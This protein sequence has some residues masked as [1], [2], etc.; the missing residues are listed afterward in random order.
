MGL[1]QWPTLYT[2]IKCANS[3]SWPK[4]G[5][6]TTTPCLFA[7]GVSTRPS[8][9]VS[10]L[11]RDETVMRCLPSVYQLVDSLWVYLSAVTSNT[12]HWP[13]T[14]TVA[15]PQSVGC[16][17]LWLAA[18]VFFLCVCVC[19]NVDKPGRLIRSICLQCKIMAQWTVCLHS[20]SMPHAWMQRTYGKNVAIGS[21][22]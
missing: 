16:L 12:L 15:V 17:N 11:M 14:L 3:R 19:E 18:M 10:V 22:C 13:C 6:H 9:C 2:Q 7:I 8:V 5:T 20:L 1:D 21:A 4:K